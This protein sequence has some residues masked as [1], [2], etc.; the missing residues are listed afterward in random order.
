MI[1]D[2]ADVAKVEEWEALS[3]TGIQRP[4]KE[5]STLAQQINDFATELF[6]RRLAN[7]TQIEDDAG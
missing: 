3:E 7:L 1:Q 2:P 5:D 6:E 4:S